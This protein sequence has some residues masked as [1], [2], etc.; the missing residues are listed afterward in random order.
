MCDPCTPDA[1]LEAVRGLRVAEPDL[2]F[3]PLL[4]KLREQQP[5][6]RS[7]TKEVREALKVLKAESE[8]AAAPP[9]A[10]PP[11]AEESVAPSNAALSLACIGCARL[12]SD[13]DD[14]REKHPICDK[15][16]DEQLPTTYLCGVN[17][18]ANPGAWEL[19][20]VF[21][22][23]LRKLRKVRE[24]GGAA[25]QLDREVAEGQARIAA[26]SGT[27]YSKLLAEGARHGS[28]W[29]KAGK[30]YRE[31][32]AL[33]PDKP[34]AY[35]NLGA[36]LSNSGH[37]VEAAQRYLEAKERFPVGSEHWALATAAA[38][39]M[40]RAEQCDEVAKPEWWNDEGLKALSARV[41]RAAPNDTHAAQ[42]L[43]TVLSGYDGAWEMGPRSAA[44]LKEAATYYERSAAL[45]SAPALKADRARL[46]A[47]CRSQAEA[48]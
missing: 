42:M 34:T 2:D 4:A 23:K 6:L 36:A 1:L 45:C 13:M 44:E 5:D 43:A 46:A 47:W 37:D 28:N 20:G 17:C 12:P 18:P 24:D 38:F 31:A 22:K 25:L 32:I 15:C 19:H 3:K 40:L 35:F 41:V 39:N 26:Q 48:M 21:H 11:A 29:R 14:E 10:A 9:A 7:P 33:K 8:A 16:R 30:A 27:E